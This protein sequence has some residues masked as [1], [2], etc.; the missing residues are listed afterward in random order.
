MLVQTLVAET[1][2]E[3]F[4]IGVL[5][6]LAGFNEEELNAAGMRPGQQGPATELLAVIRSDRFWQPACLGQLVEHPRELHAAHRSLRDNR[7]GFMRGVI[8]DRKV[9][10]D[11]P[12]R[13]PVEH[14][15]H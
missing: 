11:T 15:I 2:I 14:E 1:P 9:L 4:D 5:I 10:D 13:R 12:F 8:D 7:Y 3:G 6:R